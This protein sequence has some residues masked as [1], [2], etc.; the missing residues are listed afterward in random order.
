MCLNLSI[1]LPMVANDKVVI[2]VS[3]FSRFRLRQ[4]ACLSGC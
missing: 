2:G 4:R 3:E 1:P